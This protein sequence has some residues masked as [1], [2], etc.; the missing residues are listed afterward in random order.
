MIARKIPIAAALMAGVMLLGGCEMLE[1]NKWTPQEPAAISIDEDGVVTEIIQE[2]LDEAYY[3]AAELQN[4]IT[5]EVKE[6]ND[7]NGEDTIIVKEMEAAEG[8]ISLKMEYASAADYASFNNTEFYYDSII[9]AQLSGYLFDVSYKK[10]SNGVVQG[11]SVSG[12]EVIKRMD[13]QVLIL[14]APMEVHVPGDVLFTSTNADVLAA[15]VVN[16]TGESK[17][18]EE[19]EEGLILPSNA[20]YKVEDT[21]SFAEATAANRVYIIFD[22]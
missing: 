5:S 6:Y 2:T 4:M 11:S 21:T 9:G 22:M 8:K 17:E 7:K 19:E 18:D 14:R 20:V 16:A 15:D 13:K 12:S 10:V 3:D 1:Q